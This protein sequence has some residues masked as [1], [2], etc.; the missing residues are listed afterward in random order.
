V[1]SQKNEEQHIIDCFGA[2][3]QNCILLDIGANDGITFS[4]S[5]RMI[6]L[7]AQAHLVEPS[8]RA[9]RRLKE[10]YQF[11]KNVYLYNFGILHKD[12]TATLFES[13]TLLNKDDVALVSSYSKGQTEQWRKSNV[14]YEE[15][16]TEIR[17][18][19][20][21]MLMSNTERFDLISIDVEGFEV[22]ILTQ[23]NLE[24]Y[25]VKMLIVEWNCR[26]NNK[27]TMV[28]YCAKYGLSLI[29]EN[30]ENLIFKK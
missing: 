29:D 27:A 8:P 14:N 10:L 4:N 19:E 24:K 16:D 6:E 21:F 23:I 9:F 12:T 2:D 26:E 13:D 3:S 28:E 17:T 30:N 11:N 25:A 20:T 7:G 5:R 22:Q 18:F 15:V 1:Y